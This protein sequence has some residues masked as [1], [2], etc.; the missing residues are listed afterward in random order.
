MW[1]IKPMP[2]A[3]AP[4]A[5]PVSVPMRRAMLMAGA[6]SLSG[7]VT[8][9][10]KPA[11]PAPSMPVEVKPAEPKRPQKVA[12]ALGG[13]A[14]RGFAHVGVIK[15]LEAHGI[16]PDM[17]IGT[18]AGSVVGAMYAGGYSGFELQ[19]IALAMDEA[20]LGDW[21]LP[22]KGFLKGEALAQYVNK[23]LNNRPIERLAKPFAAVATDL[24]SGE[25]IIFQRGDTG[26]AVRASSA[27]PGVFQP[28][29]ISGRDYV[30]G[31]LVSPIPV[32]AARK[33]GAD[34]VIAVDISSQAQFADPSGAVGALL[35]TFTIMGQQLGS[36]EKAEADVVIRPQL[37]AIKGTDFQAR[38]VSILEGERAA[39]AV[40]DTLK[41]KLKA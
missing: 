12:L 5:E 16:V 17:V 20:T 30:D 29:Q 2:L 26:T 10:P 21:A 11:G 4:V 35:Q 19:K 15:T 14:A 36:Y 27:V 23:V 41:R 18:S 25:M 39:L 34:Y 24:R 22:V 3:A 8:T 6:L 13:G 32:R 31:G 33:L 40:I 38:N 37:G 7:C 9:S 28:V 1:S